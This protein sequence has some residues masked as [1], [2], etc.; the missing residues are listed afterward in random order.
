[1]EKD[2]GLAVSLTV[3][4]TGE[5]DGAEVVQIYLSGR[6][7]DVVMPRIELKAY[8]R[9]EV[10]AG[11]KARVTI[12]VPNEAFCY[13]D[14]KMNFGM[15]NGDYTVSVATSCTDIKKTFEVSVKDGKLTVK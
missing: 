8:K 9:V 4:N 13:Y 7:C 1:M 5:R 3:E 6:N 10:A 14:R 2:G 12:E 15:H 11:Q